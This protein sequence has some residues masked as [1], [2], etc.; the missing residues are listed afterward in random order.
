MQASLGLQGTLLPTSVQ[1]QSRPGERATHHVQPRRNSRVVFYDLPALTF[2]SSVPPADR[3]VLL[4]SEKTWLPPREFPHCS[5]SRDETSKPRG[6]ANPTRRYRRPQ[7][8]D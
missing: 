7:C 2:R 4:C 1:T 3:R 8:S 5:S 6:T